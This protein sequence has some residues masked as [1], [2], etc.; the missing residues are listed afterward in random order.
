MTFNVAAYMNHLMRDFLL[1][2]GKMVRVDLPDRKAALAL[3]ERTIVNC[4]GYGAKSLWG[5]D[6]LVPVR[7]QINWLAPQPEARFGLLFREVFVVSRGDG[8]I[9]QYVGPNDDFGYG[10]EG[11]TPDLDETEKSLAMIA[12]LFA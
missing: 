5:A 8:L 12:P 2:G 11:E 6:E 3:A 7:G 1:L 4:T 9:V 10:I